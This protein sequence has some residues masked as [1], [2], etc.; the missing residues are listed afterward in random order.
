MA[1]RGRVIG[2]LQPDMTFDA[3]LAF[4]VVYTRLNEECM[5][6]RSP[7]RHLRIRIT[8]SLSRL[9]IATLLSPT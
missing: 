9:S 2:R 5:G 6:F 8:L 4:A 3:Q 1:S 7:L